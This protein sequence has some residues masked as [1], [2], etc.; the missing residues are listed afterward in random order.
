M[1]NPALQPVQQRVERLAGGRVKG[2]MIRAHL[3]LLLFPLPL[4][5]LAGI[6]G[7]AP[8]LPVAALALRVVQLALLAWTTGAHLGIRELLLT[9]LLDL[10]QFG[11]QVVPYFDDT[12]T[13][14]GHTARIGPNTVLREVL[15]TAA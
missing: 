2:S 3:E 1:T 11:A 14:R 12:V 5:I 9:P 10:L 4:A 8:I 7:A 15:D 6:A 13:W